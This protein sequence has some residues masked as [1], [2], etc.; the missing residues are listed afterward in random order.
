MVVLKIFSK[1]LSNV[2]P[3]MINEITIFMKNSFLG[4]LFL[5]SLPLK[6]SIANTSKSARK[7]G[8]LHIH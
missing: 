7:F 4:K 1:S 5:E 6:F 2:V 3:I 8:F